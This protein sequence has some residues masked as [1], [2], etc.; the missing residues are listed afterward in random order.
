MS[1]QPLISHVTI[2]VNGSNVDVALMDNLVNITIDHSLDVPS[3]ATMS[4]HDDDLSVTN[5]EKFPLG[6]KLDILLS[7]ADNPQN[8]Q[9][10]FKGEITTIAPEFGQGA[11]N[12][13]VLTIL[14][15][16]KSHR[17][18]RETKTKV[19]LNVKDSDIAQQIAGSAGL[20]TEIEATSEVF[21]H[22]YQNALTD[23]DFLKQRAGRIGFEVFVDDEKLYFR[24]PDPTGNAID[25]TWGENLGLFRPV[26]TVAHQVNE[27][28]VQGWDPKKKEKIMGR[29]TTSKTHPQ[30]NIG[31]WG[32]AVAQSKLSA[33]TKLEVRQPVQSQADANRVAQAILDNINGDFVTAEGACTVGLPDLRAGQ[34]VNIKGVGNKFSG[35]YKLTSV[36]HDYTSGNFMTVFQVTGSQ[37]EYVSRMVSADRHEDQH[38]WGGVVPAIVTNN[39]DNEEDWGHVKV[40]FPWLDQDAESFWARLTGPGFGPDRGFYFMPEV[41]D[42]VLVAF[43]QGDFNRPY[44]IGGLYNGKDKPAVPIAET[45]SGG[46]V[47]TRA[48]RTRTGHI[49]RF[50]DDNPG[51]SIEI[52][53]A[54]QNTSM[55]MDAQGKKITLDSKGDLDITTVGNIKLEATGKIDIKATQGLTM[56]GQT[57]DM[58]ALS[59]ANL[60][61]NASMTVKGT[62]LS[63]QGTASAEV[64]GTASVAIT[65]G[66][67]RIN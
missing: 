44:I 65:G 15:Y 52:I 31:G 46:K 60:Q 24:K 13:V 11:D 10:A 2:K 18:H 4:F 67:V 27:V 23:M 16:D 33:A 41:N 43:E 17:L 55:K 3:V 49:I 5:S 26:A 39:S 14:A 63:A 61:A 59:N 1:E 20:A 40:K 19:W 66:I 21:K 12:Q 9:I 58:T 47:K 8:L 48:I 32:G 30:I 6:G 54:K 34:L 36:E 29:A 53:D 38:H 57:V 7:D 28:I 25:L 62:Q 37:P 45:V 50:V 51:G 56:Q 35:K 42:E 64:K 22:V